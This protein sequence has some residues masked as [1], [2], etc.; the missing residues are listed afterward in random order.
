M[1]KL[2]KKKKK[3]TSKGNYD[4]NSIVELKGLEKVRRK[5]GMYL[6]ERGDMMAFRSGKEL[7]D[8]VYDEF[9]AGR[10]KSLEVIASNDNNWYICAD[11]STGVPVGKNADGDNTLELVFGTL[12]AG[13]KFNDKAYGTSSGTH[14][15]GAACTTAVSGVMEI[16][17]CWEGQWYYL[18][19]KQ[20]IKQKEIKKVSKLPAE[21]SSQLHSK[22]GYGTVIRYELDQTIVSADANNK[23]AKKLKPA[24]LDYK[25]VL[26][27]FK[28]L[29]MMNPGFEIRVKNADKDSTKVYLNKKGL[30]SIVQQQVEENEW[31]T[32]GRQPMVLEHGNLKICLQWTSYEN[33]DKFKS[34][35]NCSPTRDHGKH[36]DGVRAALFKALQ[37]VKKASDKFKGQ[38]ALPGMVGFINWNMSEAEFSS[39]TKDRLVSHVDKDIEELAFEAFM[40]YFSNKAVANGVI[41]RAI[42]VSKGRDALKSVM[43]AAAQ[44]RKGSKGAMLPGSLLQSTTNKAMERELYVVEGDSA[45]GT[46][47]QARDSRTQEVFKLT[48]KI[49]NA[50]R[51]PLHEV[52]G[53]PRIQ[54][55][56]VSVGIDMNSLKATE[57]DLAKVHFSVDKMRI[58]YI[59][60]LMDA[61][62][63]G[64]HIVN[65]FLTLVYRIMPDMLRQKRVYIVDGK[66]FLGRYKEKNYYGDSND[67]VI[68]QMPK[69]V[70]PLQY[71]TRAKGWGEVDYE[72]LAEMAFDPSTRRLICVDYPETSEAEEYFRSI[73]GEDTSVRK[74]LLG[75][76]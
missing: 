39:Q 2:E 53:N 65:L 55:F 40:D 60:L 59:M 20:G 31:T 69:M 51:K 47:K 36:Y 58:G 12:H 34:Y 15:V 35:V 37:K 45:G 7:W 26:P 14:G 49:S 23:R 32:I 10:N 75:I 5:P 38:D 21:I 30:A 24:K 3:K 68:A 22:K 61:D 19:Y 33:D 63:D 25:F 72:A 64:N 73:V 67:E 13:G 62:S 1:A 56:L 6:G 16:Y 66:L 70:N 74:K 76:D 52:L 71:I 29:A 18:Q 46:A 54:E 48:G 41:K 8:N 50:L 44:V 4:V 11:K 9:A 42:A 28:N 57:D 27:Y 43:Q 17:S